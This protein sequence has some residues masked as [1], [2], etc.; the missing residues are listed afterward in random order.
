MQSVCIWGHY[1]VPDSA[2]GVKILGEVTLAHQERY[3]SLS[4]SRQAGGPRRVWLG[5]VAVA[6]VND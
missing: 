4:G 2:L 6:L 3:R 1:S 5:S